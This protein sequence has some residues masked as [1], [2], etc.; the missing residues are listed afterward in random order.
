MGGGT[1]AVPVQVPNVVGETQAA[2]TTDLTNAGFLTAVVTAYS[3]SV[4]AGTIISQDPIGGTFALPGSTVTITVSLGPQPVDEQ[5]VGGHYWPTK[6]KKP[7]DYRPELD[8]ERQ[9]DQ[10]GLRELLERAAGLIEEVEKV[11]EP[12]VQAQ[13]AEVRDHFEAIRAHAERTEARKEKLTAVQARVDRLIAEAVD[14]LIVQASDVLTELIQEIE[15]D[16]DAP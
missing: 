8:D 3:S 16:D 6:Q 9:R 4:A 14:R 1:A 11:N 15:E 5:P 12:E 13:A 10:Q 2:G 7:K